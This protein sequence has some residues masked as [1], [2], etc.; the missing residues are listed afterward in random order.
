MVFLINGWH[1]MVTICFTI[2]FLFGTAD[3]EQN[4]I[5]TMATG[6]KK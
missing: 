1:I 4:L 6:G 5:D 2:I 3:Y